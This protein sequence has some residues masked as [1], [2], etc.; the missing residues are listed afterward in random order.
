MSQ[1]GH[2]RRRPAVPVP[3]H[4]QPSAL[5]AGTQLQLP[6]PGESLHFDKAHWV[7]SAITN[8]AL[9][10][11]RHI[12]AELAASRG[13]NPRIITETGR[14]LTVVLARHQ[15]GDMIAWSE[16]SAAAALQGPEHHPHRRD[17]RSRRAPA[18][19]PGP[20][21]H[22]PGGRTAGAAARADGR[23]RGALA[24]HPHP[25]RASQPSP[26]RAHRPAEPQPGPPTPAR[27]VQALRPPA[28]GHHRRRHRRHRAP[29][30]PACAGRPSS[31]CARCSRH[32]KKTG[33]I[34]ADPARGL[35]T[36]QRPLILIQPLQP[37]RDRRRP[38]PPPSHPP[39]ASRSP[40]PLC[41]RPGPRPSANCTSTTSTSATG[42]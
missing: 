41:T 8:Q 16:L 30:P 15:A 9:Q 22:L 3:G 10:Q 14:A 34:F 35:G 21:L 19:R 42:G 20:L 12:A 4:P 1:L 13:W 40:W 17:P 23:R 29:C 7:A 5:A 24:A 27:V 26:Q 38:P 25:G 37:E 18:R 11:A 6:I 36:G 39:P 2:T 33:T 32:C 28:R 31:R